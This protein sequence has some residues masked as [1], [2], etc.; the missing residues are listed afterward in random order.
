[1]YLSTGRDT[2]TG[3]G[4]SDT[5][6]WE[7]RLEFGQGDVVTDFSATGP[8]ADTL[9]FYTPDIAG[10]TTTLRL[11]NGTAATTAQATFIYNAVNDTL[12]WDPDGTGAAAALAIVRLTNV[13]ALSSANFDLWT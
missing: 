3:G 8:G 2:M 1:M 5:F 10:M 12:F 9:A 6:V 4:G 13:A 11:V 7:N